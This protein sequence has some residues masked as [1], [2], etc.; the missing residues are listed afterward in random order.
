M[1]ATKPRKSRSPKAGVCYMD[2][3]YAT[4]ERPVRW[5][6]TRFLFGH[7]HAECWNR[8]VDGSSHTGAEKAALH[9]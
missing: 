3:E 1:A 7:Y 8:L 9:A 5:H 2:A 4:P 6:E